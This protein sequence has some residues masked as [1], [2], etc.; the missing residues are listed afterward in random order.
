M[1]NNFY[2][3]TFLSSALSSGVIAVLGKGP[4][5]PDE[6]RSE[7][8]IDFYPEG[9]ES[10]LD[11]GVSLGELKK[12]SNGYSLRS[13]FAKQLANPMNDTWVA[14]FRARV[15]AFY[16]YILRTP[17][18]LKEQKLF[19]VDESY[20][21]LFARSSRTVE[22]LLLE[23][24]DDIVPRNAPCRMLE[25]GCGSGVYI[26]KACEVSPQ[27]TA[28]GLEAQKGAADFAR[29]NIKE[30]GFEDRVSIEHKDIRQYV[31]AEKFDLV[32]FHNLI[33]YFPLYER[34]D[35]LRHINGLLTDHGR[36][37]LTT[38]TKGPDPA[39]QVMDLWASMTDGYGP[40]PNPEQLYKQLEAAGYRNIRVEKALRD[41]HIFQAGK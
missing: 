36:L 4:A 18:M 22:P 15:E 20:A 33:Y 10:W 25:V 39:V 23:V 17:V 31:S 26:R 9:L 11:L 38:I 6:I 16:N 21:E 29:N 3:A 32:T 1:T 7:L 37:A 14:Y 13:G 30:W 40:L 19:S 41:F 8:G 34:E 5:S 28:V 2:R 27:L 12:S 24:V 35:L